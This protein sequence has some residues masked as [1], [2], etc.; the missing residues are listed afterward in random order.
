M[1]AI[2]PCSRSF[3]TELG[4]PV[5]VSTTEKEEW[6][7]HSVETSPNT[8]VQSFAFNRFNMWYHGGSISSEDTGSIDRQIS[9]TGSLEKQGPGEAEQRDWSQL[10]G[11]GHLRLLC[12]D[13]SNSKSGY[14][15]T[16]GLLT[17]GKREEGLGYG[18]GGT[19]GIEWAKMKLSVLSWLIYFIF[20]Y[21]S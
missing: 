15:G 19:E 4:F 17:V 11:S 12:Q 9:H 8:W 13:K 21:C 7:S 10:F 6:V 16:E 14:E 2:W 18:V 3:W 5:G 20:S 1:G